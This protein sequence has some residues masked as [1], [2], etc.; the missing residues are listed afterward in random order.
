MRS[1]HHV[2]F[3]SLPDGV[4]TYYGI[5]ILEEDGV[6]LAVISDLPETRSE[7]SDADLCAVAMRAQTTFFSSLSPGDVRWMWKPSESDPFEVTFRVGYDMDRWFFAQPRKT[8]V[9]A[10]N[11]VTW[12]SGIPAFKAISEI[13]RV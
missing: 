11:E 12:I 7:L 1:R 13:V 9:L 4:G 8:P 5:S 10:E 3:V 2:L 6:R